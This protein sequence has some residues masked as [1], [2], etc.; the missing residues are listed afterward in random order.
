MDP[1]FITETIN[2][3]YYQKYIQ[4]IDEQISSQNELVKIQE[5]L[6]IKNDESLIFEL[7]VQLNFLKIIFNQLTKLKLII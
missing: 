1:G 7:I 4:I 3:E 2:N 5:N 6:D